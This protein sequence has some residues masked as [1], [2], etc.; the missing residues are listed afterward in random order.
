MTRASVSCAVAAASATI[1]SSLL[2]A[3]V[4][5]I[6]VPIE[7][8][9]TW[10]SYPAFAW[11][12]GGDPSENIPGTKRFSPPP[13][14]PVARFSWENRSNLTVLITRLW[15]GLYTPS[16]VS[17]KLLGAL[18]VLLLIALAGISVWLVTADRIAALVAAALV[19]SDSRVLAAGLCDARPDLFIAVFALGL[20]ITVWGAIER[21]NA[22]TL[23]GAIVLA[24]L[25][26]TLHATTANAIA[27]FLA[28]L[29]VLELANPHRAAG[30]SHRRGLTLLF[31]GLLVGAF[32][33]KQPFL[34]LV[35]PTQVPL[36][37]ETE[38]R[39]NAEDELSKIIHNGL[40][41][42][43]TMEWVRWKEYFFAANIA[44][45][46]FVVAGLVAAVLLWRRRVALPAATWAIALTVAF[47]AAALAMFAVDSHPIV[48]HAIVLAVLGY[49]G[50]AVAIAVANEVG[51][52]SR[53]HTVVFIAILLGLT[54]LLKAGHFYK[55]YQQYVRPQISN[56][57]EQAAL[58]S[59]IQVAG[60]V[61][62]V[63]PAEIWPFL[64]D[65]RQP[66]TLIDDTSALYRDGDQRFRLD[67]DHADL[68]AVN[69]LVLNKR[70]YSAWHFDKAVAEWRAQ[71]LI[72]QLS[73]VGDCDRTVECLQIYKLLPTTRQIEAPRAE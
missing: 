45:F 12:Q 18:Q 58:R 31:A 54:A 25:L 66:L 7:C 62:I 34:D 48:Q 5:F 72:E 60:D 73:A 57:A 40:R 42:K 17:L 24:L 56:P 32:F 36:S 43:A 37:A 3:A 51:I 1:I 64:S 63:G 71:G 9:G 4:L 19:L 30:A 29:G 10:Y 15:F 53:A 47:P 2:V 14:R 33:A 39:H 28:L 38:Y 55:L 23:A 13:E 8:D 21:R 6:Y 61:T 70:Y 35:I 68:G 50:S 46:S 41:A 67:V 26:A 69:Y 49:I 11:S 65:R 20:L 59:A 27:F 22:F 44:Q 16:W 52:W